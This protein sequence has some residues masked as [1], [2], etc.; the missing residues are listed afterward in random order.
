MIHGLMDAMINMPDEIK[1]VMTV[2]LA[3]VLWNFSAQ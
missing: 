3:D 1:L 2:R